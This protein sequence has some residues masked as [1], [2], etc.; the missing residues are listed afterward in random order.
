MM[1]QGDGLLLVVIAISLV[2][3]AGDVL[4]GGAVATALQAHLPG[5]A[6]GL[7]L[8]LRQIARFAWPLLALP[9]IIAFA[10]RFTP[11]V[12]PLL[13]GLIGVIERVTGA[14]GGAARWFALALVIV[15]ATIVIQR[16][17]FGYASTKLQE[18]VIYLH[19][20]L[21]LLA[22]ASTLL[23]DGHVRVDIFY[24]KAS[25]RGKAW[26]DLF[27]TYLTLMPMSALILWSSQ[28]YMA[29]TWRILERSREGDGLPFIF[30]LKTAIPVF[31]VLLILQGFAMAARAALT[32][33]AQP[34]PPRP[35][36]LAE[37]EV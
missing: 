31:A 32:L 35:K 29:S 12:F 37:G 4:S 26:I 21:F 16:Y 19:A 30:L 17:V 27:G 23:A 15:T 10:G 13:R 25:E 36:N 22:S 28:G 3:S 7:G 8:T 18:S 6:A 5:I 20:L 1:R 2:L 24:S 33:N 9:L 14:F 34:V 11:T